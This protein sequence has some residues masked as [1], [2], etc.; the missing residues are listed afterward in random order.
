MSLDKIGK[1]TK[2]KSML[3]TKAV[4][5]QLGE[6]IAADATTLAPATDANKVRL[7]AGAFTPSEDLVIGDLTFATFTGST[8]IAGA[9]GTQLVGVDPATGDQIVT[10]KDPAGGYRWECSAAPA[11]PEVIYGYA[12]IDNG[13]TKLLAVEAF[14]DP[15]TISDAGQEI[16]IGTVKLTFVADPLS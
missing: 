14:D 3:P 7:I 9:T 8:A 13:A 11:T 16:N 6:L 10:I 5:L 2:G 12:L 15:I 4:R 1:P